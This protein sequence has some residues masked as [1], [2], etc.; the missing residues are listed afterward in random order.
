MEDMLESRVEEEG[1]Y[2]KA[3]KQVLL[4]FHKG[5][6]PAVAVEFA[7]RSLPHEVRPGFVELEE[8]CREAKKAGMAV[9]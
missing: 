1:K 9:A 8:A 5:S 3:L 7:R 4:A 2:F 6:V